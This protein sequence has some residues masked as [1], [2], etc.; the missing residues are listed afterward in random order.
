[1][2]RKNEDANMPS[3][4]ANPMGMTVPKNWLYNF[5]SQDKKKGVE[6]GTQW[7]T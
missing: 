2:L 1:M 3:T 5:G 7:V 4:K 6:W